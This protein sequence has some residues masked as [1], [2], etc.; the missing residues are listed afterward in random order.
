[1]EDKKIK[2]PETIVVNIDDKYG[3]SCFKDT[4]NKSNTKSRKPEGFVEIYSVDANGIKQKVGKSNLV[5]LAGREWIVSRICNTENPNITPKQDEFISWFGL[6]D[7]GCPVSDP[8]NPTTPTS[9]LTSLSNDIVIHETDKDCADLRTGGY[10][11]H[12]IES[13]VFQQDLLNEDAWLILKVTTTLSLDDAVGNLSEAG[14]FTSSSKVGEHTGPFNI[15][16]I[17]TFPTIVKD[18]TRQL[19]FY[20][21]LYC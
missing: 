8:L 10:Y 5:L 4:V 16:S 18:N 12:P 2:K 14:L 1:M 3:G 19:I 20:W 13:F 6:G 7:G 21:Y 15:F 17:V 9:D 11:K